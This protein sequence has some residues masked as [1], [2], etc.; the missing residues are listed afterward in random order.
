VNALRAAHLDEAHTSL[1]ADLENVA[2]L[3][4]RVEDAA[5]ADAAPNGSV[6]PLPVNHP[7]RKRPTLPAAREEIERGVENYRTHSGCGEMPA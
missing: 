4:A 1:L 7:M 5:A 3:I 2:T 6:G